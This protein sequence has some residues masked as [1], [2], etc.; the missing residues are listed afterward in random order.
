MI[1]VLSHL[2]KNWLLKWRGRGP[3]SIRMLDTGVLLP[4]YPVI[5]LKDETIVKKEETKKGWLKRFFR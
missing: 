2:R 3:C 1:D 5:Q 4:I